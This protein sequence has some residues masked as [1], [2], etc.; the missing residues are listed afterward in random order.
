LARVCEDYENMMNITLLEDRLDGSSNFNSWKSRL[1]V[2]LQEEELLWVIQKGLPETTINEEKEER[3]ED[4]VNAR[5]TIIYSSS[6]IEGPAS[7]Y[8]DDK[9]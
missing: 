2:T 6:Y 4:N 8:Q 3:N 1:Q 7:K 5:K 9:R